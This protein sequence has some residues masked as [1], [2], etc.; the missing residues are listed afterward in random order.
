MT[1]PKADVDPAWKILLTFCKGAHLRARFLDADGRPSR[2]FER[3]SP[4]PAIRVINERAS[5]LRPR[6]ILVFGV[7]ALETSGRSAKIRRSERN[8]PAVREGGNGRVSQ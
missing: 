2:R 5:C 8:S 7:T 3:P 4:R 1:F 6:S